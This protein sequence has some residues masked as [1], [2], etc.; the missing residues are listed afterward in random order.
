[1][2]NIKPYKHK[3]YSSKQSKYGYMAPLPA[4]ILLNAPSGTG[5]TVALTNLI[6]DIYKDC[7]EKIYIFSPTVFIDDTWTIVKK[8]IENE[9]DIKHSDE[10]PIYFDNFEERDLKNIIDTQEGIIKYMKEKEY[11]HLYNICIIID[12]WADNERVVRKN[13]ELIKL[14]TKGKHWYISTFITSQS[15][16]QI[17]PVVRKNATQLFIFRLRN[18]KDLE[19]ILDELSGLYDKKTLD[20]IYRIATD[21]KHGFLYVDLMQSDKTK[22]FFKNLNAQIVVNQN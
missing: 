19:A 9:M 1:M 22:M 20:K 12:D 5:K 4:R 15:Y 16:T 3:E 7:F 11:K 14:F 18:H 8:Y 10:D 21:D 17:S 2:I 13:K 6:M